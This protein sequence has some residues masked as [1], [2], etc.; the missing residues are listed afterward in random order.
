MLLKDIKN[1]LSCKNLTSE[2][3]LEK[4][5]KFCFGADLMSDVLR[6]CKTGSL[7]LTGLTNAQILQVSEIMD[8][9][10]IIFVRGKE[11]DK[12]IIKQAEEKKLPLLSTN[13]LMFDTCG[14]LYENGLRGGKTRL[15]DK[16]ESRNSLQSIV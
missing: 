9:K 6:F 8:L 4:D 7:L 15:K 3:L 10:G 2:E 13:N 1:L 12:N 16:N 11:P 5:V 14:V